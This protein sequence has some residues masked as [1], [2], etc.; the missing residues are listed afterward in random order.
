MDETTL[1]HPQLF[2]GCDAGI[3]T[4]PADLLRL[5]DTY[6]K[7]SETPHPKPPL[8]A[9]E[10]INEV[11]AATVDAVHNGTP[12]PD[13]ARIDQARADE[14][15]Y[16]DVIDMMGICLQRAASSTHGYIAQHADE[17]ISQHL[18]VAFDKMWQ[19]FRD[20]WRLLREY[21]ETE[22]RRLLDAPSKIR[23]AADTVEQAVAH[24][25]ALT[26]AR[27]DLYV[28]GIRCPED[29]NNYHGSIRNYFTVFPNRMRS[30]RTPWH[31]MSTRLYLGWHADH[32]GELW[33]PTPAEQAKAVKAESDLGNP[34]RFAH[35]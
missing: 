27:T 24:F 3:Y 7:V 14:R 5:R 25:G 16:Q 21:G 29:P 12:L 33:M 2:A 19:D 4:L 1:R 32:G 22:P 15:V 10:V 34:I 30:A 6:V 20:A 31:G 9:W 8:N 26:A 35:R 23:K 28:R 18:A 13:A 17:I 11:A